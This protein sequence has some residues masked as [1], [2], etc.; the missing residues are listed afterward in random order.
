M[1]SCEF[2]E[3]FKNTFFTE[4]L[5]ATASGLK[6]G[7]VYSGLSEILCHAQAQISRSAQF[8]VKITRGTEKKRC[9]GLQV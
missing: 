4:R 7:W 9:I 5:W 3:I 6:D 1:F 2:W 8:S